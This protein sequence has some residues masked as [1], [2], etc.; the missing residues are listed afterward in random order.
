M[1]PELEKLLGRVE[2][3]IKHNRNIVGPFKTAKEMNTYLDLHNK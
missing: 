2:K 1:T 3:D